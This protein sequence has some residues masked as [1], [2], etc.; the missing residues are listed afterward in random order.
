MKKYTIFLYSLVMVFGLMGVASAI[1]ITIG[2]GSTLN[3]SPT[4]GFINYS[5]TAFSFGTSTPYDLPAGSS[6]SLDLFSVTLNSGLGF[7]NA[8]VAV[9]FQTPVNT[10]G[11]GSGFWAGGGI[12]NFGAGIINWNDVINVPFGSGDNAGLLTLAL[13]DLSG[14]L[15]G[16]PFTISGTLTNSS[17]SV[18]SAPVPEPATILLMGTGLLGLVAYS[19]KR[20]SKRS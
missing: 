11:A 9:N 8:N 13:N 7:G 12:F 10:L 17:A 15:I 2:S 18:Q 4:L 16:D 5:Y 20:I 6:V 1:P 3:L 19:R 14:V